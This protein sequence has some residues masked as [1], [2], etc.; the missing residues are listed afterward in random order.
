MSQTVEEVLRYRPPVL[1]IRRLPLCDVEL[2][3]QQ[4]KRGEAVIAWLGCANHDPSQFPHPERFDIERNPKRHIP[5]GH[6]IHTCL[7]AP[8]AR[9]EAKIALTIMLERLLD[10]ERDRS[11]ELEP[12]QSV[13]IYG[14]KHVPITFTHR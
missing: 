4:I 3:G 9:L 11:Q 14:A 2:A 7:G 10:I 5:F 12:V 1:A 6:G 8:L 13:F